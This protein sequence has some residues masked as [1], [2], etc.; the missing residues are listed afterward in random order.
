ME[1]Q[2]KSIGLIGT[3]TI[4]TSWA[5]YYTAKGFKVKMYD[6]VPSQMQ[7]ALQRAKSYVEDLKR[8]GFVTEEAANI[9]I[10]NMVTTDDP[11]DAISDTEFVHES[12]TE[13]YDIKREVFNYMDARTPEDVVLASSTSGLLMSEIQKVTRHPARCLVAHPFNPPHL[14]PLVELAP[15]KQT[16]G[17]IIS[18]MKSFFEGLGKVPVVLNKEAPA[19][20]ANRLALALWREAIDIVLKGIASVEDVDKALY[21]G[22]GVRWGFMGQH[23]I[24]HLG[25]GEGG[26]EHFFE[27]FIPPL[28]QH[29]WP[30][31]AT[32]TTLPPGARDMLIEGV[33]AEMEGRSLEEVSRWRDEKLMALL[34]AVYE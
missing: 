29:F 6:I 22:P 21:A 28:E 1:T 11:G 19:H 23:L 30:S 20:I 15:G 31:L 33:Q 9:A 4:G 25:G 27:H 8:N 26:M 34:K 5:A 7:K 13:N 18:E 32:W 12:V 16:S 3:G 17:E 10:T 2:I 14:I 24:Y